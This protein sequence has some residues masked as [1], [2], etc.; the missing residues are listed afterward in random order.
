MSY[1]AEVDT[2]MVNVTTA[3]DDVSV[4]TLL[5]TNQRSKVSGA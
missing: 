4:A 5:A 3:T 2:V 1:G